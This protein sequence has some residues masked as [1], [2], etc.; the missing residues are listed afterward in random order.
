MFESNACT[1]VPIANPRAIL[2]ASAVLEPVPPSATAKSVIPVTVPPVIE[3]LFEAC[4]AIVPSPKLV[5]DVPTLLR[6]DKLLVT[7]KK[8]PAVNAASTQALPVYIFK[9]LPTVLKY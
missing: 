9:L 4:V 1:S 5:R 6:S 2:A 7:V 3:T 8:S